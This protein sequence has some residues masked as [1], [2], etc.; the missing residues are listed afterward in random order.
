MRLEIRLL[1]DATGDQAATLCDWRSGCYL[2]RL[3]IRLPLD[4]VGDQAAT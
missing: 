3:E 2:M 1:P 4:A